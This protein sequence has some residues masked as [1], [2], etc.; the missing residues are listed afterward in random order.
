MEVVEMEMGLYPLDF[1][2]SCTLKRRE[3]SCDELGGK[4]K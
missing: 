4:G 1:G 2:A 3:R